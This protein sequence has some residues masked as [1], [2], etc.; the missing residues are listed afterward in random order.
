[1]SGTR[2][3]GQRGPSAT[4]LMATRPAG[5]A[6]A[7]EAVRDE[8]ARLGD[9]MAASGEAALT[10]KDLEGLESRIIERVGEAV[11]ARPGPMTR[12]EL[13]D[14]SDRLVARVA[15]TVAGHGGP[16]SPSALVAAHAARLQV[17]AEAI[18]AELRKDR[19]TLVRLP[20]RLSR[21]LAGDREAIL[22][23]AART[24]DV[25]AGIKADVDGLREEAGAGL[26]AVSTSL[27]ALL[28]KTEEARS[29]RPLPVLWPCAAFVAGMALA[30]WTDHPDRLLRWLGF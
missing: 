3:T 23:V 19:E 25:A 12:E 14:W 21:Q 1:M 29:R 8:I 15:E 27:S 16:D 13:D 6:A 11:S 7:L 26:D 20:E 18:E 9:A 28:R 22:D 5:G 30:T 17:A 10:R 4:D 2:A 24:G